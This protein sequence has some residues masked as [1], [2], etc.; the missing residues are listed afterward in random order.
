MRQLKNKLAFIS[1]LIFL[2]SLFFNAFTVED[3][4]IIK[5]YASIEVF[6]IG[7][8]SFI[9]GGIFESFIWTANIWYFITL[10]CVFKRYYWVSILSG[11]IACLIS[12]TFMFYFEV[13]VAENGRM[14]RINSLEAGYFLW[15][16]SVLLIIFFSVYLKMK[17]LNMTDHNYSISK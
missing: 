13:L 5:N 16:S 3:F 7:P 6:V 14:A 1:I 12:G 17:K 9:G 11:L 15:L 4:G 2:I 8:V 10:F